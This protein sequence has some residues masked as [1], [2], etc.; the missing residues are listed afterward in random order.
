MAE[1]SLERSDRI[2]VVTVRDPERRNALTVE[3]SDQLVD[4]V[5]TC[6]RDPEV[7]A[8]VVTGAAPAFCAGADLTA[9]GEAKEEG[10]RRIYAGFLAV[11]GCS[12]PTIAAVNGA[13]VGAG[14]NLALACD[15][16]LAGPKARFDARFLQLGIHPG[17]GMTWMLQRLVGPQTATTMTLFGQ[18]VD[19][20]E[21]VR[22]GLAHARTG[23]DVV[24]AAREL[25]KAAADGPRDLVRTIKAT[26]RTTADLDDHAEAVTAELGPQVASIG[27]P[28]FAAKLAALKSRISARP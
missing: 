10:L 16:R 7:H 9:L 25:A 8:V 24:G 19:A 14:L 27:T 5:A 2:A 4:A 11:A 3:L 12:L 15:V 22:T 26:M 6:E 1:V 20:D 21:A 18:V 13:A 28:E 23:D 17:G